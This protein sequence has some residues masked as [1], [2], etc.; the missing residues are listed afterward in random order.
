MRRSTM[1]RCG[2][3]TN[4]RATWSSERT[5]RVS[6]QRWLLVLRDPS[7]LKQDQTLQRRVDNGA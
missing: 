7:R 3:P 2:S 5:T 1:K 4:R 6:T